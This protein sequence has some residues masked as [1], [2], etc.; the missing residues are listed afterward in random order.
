MSAR[1]LTFGETMGLATNDQAGTLTTSR[2]CTMS[3]GGAESNV[4]IALT[5]LGTAA[6]WVSRLG[7]DPFADVI[8]RELRAEGVEVLAAADPLHPTGFMLKERRTASIGS[9]TFWRSGSA[10]S[11]I[12]PDAISDELIARA[13]LV[14]ITGIPFALSSTARATAF[15]LL[16]RAKRLGIPISFD[17]NHRERL[18]ASSLAAEDYRAV[19]PYCSVVFAGDDEAAILVGDGTPAELADRLCRLGARD[20][21]IKLGSEGC[22]ARIDGIRYQLAAREVD[23]VDTVGAGDAFVAGYLSD[24]LAGR[25][26]RSRLETA[27]SAGAFACT[28]LG[29]WEGSPTRAD[30]A[31][32]DAREGIAR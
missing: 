8:R 13:D 12:T 4:A 10:A 30:L 26:A 24:L 29:D 14:H 18:R 19:I 11:R 16:D 15:D 25:D 31:L 7:T 2:S 17:V 5:R 1:V 27:I 22:L 28:S 23:V 9:V 3:F 21:V 20:A 32:L 6:T